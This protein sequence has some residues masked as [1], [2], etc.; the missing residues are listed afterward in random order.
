MLQS[1]GIIKRQKGTSESR[2]IGADIKPL[3]VFYAVTNLTLNVS[4]Y[5][6]SPGN[7]LLK[8]DI[9]MGVMMPPTSPPPFYG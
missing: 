3:S 2:Y 9:Y 4:L 6:Q 7:L 8:S 1:I 5:S